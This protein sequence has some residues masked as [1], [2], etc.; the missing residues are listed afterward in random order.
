MRD[1]YAHGS[2]LLEPARHFPLLTFHIHRPASPSPHPQSCCCITICLVLPLLSNS[3]VVIDKGAVN[4][5]HASIAWCNSL[6]LRGGEDTSLLLQVPMMVGSGGLVLEGQLILEDDASLE[7]EGLAVLRDTGTLKFLSGSISG[8]WTSNGFISLEGPKVCPQR[9]DR[10][11]RCFWSL[12]GMGA[13]RGVGDRPCIKECQWVSISAQ[14]SA[15]T[16]CIPRPG[17]LWTV[18]GC[19]TGWSCPKDFSEW[20]C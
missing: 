16:M 17:T 13:R 18:A 8:R 5:V 19:D 2:I 15:S 12:Q 1:I 10:C 6:T 11:E 14:A 9:Q 7:V 4:L 20:H 3:T